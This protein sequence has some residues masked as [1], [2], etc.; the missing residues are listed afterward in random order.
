MGRIIVGTG[1]AGWAAI[2]A[3]AWRLA[4]LRI[5]ARCEHDV[6]CYE[7]M[8]VQKDNIII[9]GLAVALAYVLICLC[10]FAILKARRARS[11]ETANG[12]QP[13]SREARA[14]PRLGVERA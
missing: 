5:V 10:V 8:Q 9:G 12:W 2:V 13:T 14:Q 7:R 3:L 1:L 11:I 4:Q 6:S